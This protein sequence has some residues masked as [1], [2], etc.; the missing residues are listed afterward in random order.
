[1]KLLFSI[2]ILL[3]TYCASANTIVE[4]STEKVSI[5][6]T[7]NSTEFADKG[8]K[9]QKAQRKKARKGQRM[10]KKRKR[11]CGNWGKRSYAG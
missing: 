9:R 6:A 7:T 8:K 11:A 2:I 5:E 4:S 3:F 1:M 10:N